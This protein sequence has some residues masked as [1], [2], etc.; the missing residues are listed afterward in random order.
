V[1][2][3]HL[4]TIHCDLPSPKET[5]SARNANSPHKP[6]LVLSQSTCPPLSSPHAHS[7]VLGPEVISN[8]PAN[9]ER[10]SVTPCET[11]P[12]LPATI[13][14]FQVVCVE[15]LP[16]GAGP[17]HTRW[18]WAYP[19]AEH[20]ATPVEGRCVVLC[21]IAHL[22]LGGRA[23]FG[24]WTSYCSHNCLHFRPRQGEC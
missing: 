4:Q 14:L 8:N 11:P 6:R 23:P 2:R 13:A 7:F 1:P 20:R 18:P 16:T 24:P 15:N 5:T 17:G 12:R 9:F 3:V 22:S 19:E 10:W 21:F